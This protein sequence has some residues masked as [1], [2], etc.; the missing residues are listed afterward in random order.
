MLVLGLEF[1]IWLFDCLCLFCLFSWLELGL[2]FWI[3]CLFAVRFCWVL[4]CYGFG[5]IIIVF[6]W[7]DLC[8]FWLG[9]YVGV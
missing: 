1:L 4:V 3:C 6:G 9:G 2:V 5:L 7:V 8:F